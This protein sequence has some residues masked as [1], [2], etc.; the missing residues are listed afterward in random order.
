M[1]VKPGGTQP[2]L[3]DTIWAGKVQETGYSAGTPKGMKQILG[4][5]GINTPY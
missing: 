1:N 3:R 2:V 4:E 5:R